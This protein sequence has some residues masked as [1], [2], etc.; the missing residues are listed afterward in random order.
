MTITYRS[1][2][3]ELIIN[4]FLIFVGYMDNPGLVDRT[5]V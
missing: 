4:G 2:L 1:T 3:V 5:L